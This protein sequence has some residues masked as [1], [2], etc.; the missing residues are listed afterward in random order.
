MRQLVPSWNTGTVFEPPPTTTAPIPAVSV[1]VAL[2]THALVPAVP[3]GRLATVTGVV[4]TK[5]LRVIEVPEALPKFAAMYASKSEILD[6]RAS[7]LLVENTGS[8]SP[9]LSASKL[10]SWLIVVM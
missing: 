2:V 7:P 6:L 3:V 9:L 1:C 10:D 5:L 8:W 4:F